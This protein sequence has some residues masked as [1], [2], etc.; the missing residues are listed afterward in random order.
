MF[1]TLYALHADI[2][3]VS[4]QL[5][6]KLLCNPAAWEYSQRAQLSG[7]FRLIMDIF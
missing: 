6:K 5:K 3:E 2:I 1:T 7:Y 4:W